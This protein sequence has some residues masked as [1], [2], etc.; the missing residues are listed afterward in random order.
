MSLINSNASHPYS[1]STS[2]VNKKTPPPLP[3]RSLKPILKDRTVTEG[4]V[5]TSRAFTEPVQQQR[6]AKLAGDTVIKYQSAPA[7][8]SNHHA[9]PAS[10]K[11]PSEPDV[12]FSLNPKKMIDNME[13]MVKDLERAVPSPSSESKKLWDKVTDKKIVRT[14][15]SKFPTK[16]SAER[17][18][19]IQQFK[20]IGDLLMTVSNPEEQKQLI[21]QYSQQLTRLQ[22]TTWGQDVQKTTPKLFDKLTHT[23][24]AL[25]TH[26]DQQ[27][28]KG[29]EVR[30]AKAIEFSEPSKVKEKPNLLKT[31]GGYI[32]QTDNLLAS[33]R[34]QNIKKNN[35][36]LF[37]HLLKQQKELKTHQ[38]NLRLTVLEDK[39]SKATNLTEMRQLMQTIEM[40]ELKDGQNLLQLDPTLTD[41]LTNIKNELKGK[42]YENM[43]PNLT[44][45]DMRSCI[46]DQHPLG[47]TISLNIGDTIP[48]SL[49]NEAYGDVSQKMRGD[50]L[51]HALAFSVDV[52]KSLNTDMKALQ[53]DLRESEAKLKESV[54]KFITPTQGEIDQSP[55]KE[56]YER[57]D[58]QEL[59]NEML[60]LQS[61]IAEAEKNLP[62]LVA[63]S[64]PASPFPSREALA[65]HLGK[66]EQLKNIQDQLVKKLEDYLTEQKTQTKEKVTEKIDQYIQMLSQD[67][68]YKTL[69]DEATILKNEAN[70]LKEAADKLESEIKMAKT[71][72][73]AKAKTDQTL[74]AKNKFAKKNNEYISKERERDEVGKTLTE[75]NSDLQRLKGVRDTV[76]NRLMQLNGAYN[77]IEEG[78]RRS[79]KQIK[80]IDEKLNVLKEIKGKLEKLTGL[81]LDVMYQQPEL[82]KSTEQLHLALSG[83][84]PAIRYQT[85]NPSNPKI[86][87]SH[88]DAELD[89]I[90]KNETSV[91]H[92]SR[93]AQS[94]AHDL[95]TINAELLS[96][97][98]H[99]ELKY[100]D[101]KSD[102]KG[103]NLKN[104]TK[105]YNAVTNNVT[106]N[107][108]KPASHITS[109]SKTMDKKEA[110]KQCTRMLEFYLDV[111]AECH[112]MQD[113]NSLFAIASSFSNSALIPII[114]NLSPQDQKRVEKYQTLARQG[115]GEWKAKNKYRPSIPAPPFLF[116]GISL[117]SEFKST[118]IDSKALDTMS[119][120]KTVTTNVQK[121]LKKQDPKRGTSAPLKMYTDLHQKLEE[122]QKTKA[123]DYRELKDILFPAS[124]RRSA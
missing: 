45:S 2:E 105:T 86:G 91:E 113:Y 100:S 80:S 72:D 95:Y 21:A 89:K 56:V 106:A 82:Q 71:P 37:D 110:A 83:E 8:P 35:P 88:L 9:T 52:A 18:K 84:T 26:L 46:Y 67:L 99:S 29:V 90:T 120:L 33:E 14:F 111:A 115:M 68:E 61:E 28:V 55:L 76:N 109:N 58:Y 64:N 32:S 15:L 123:P 70:S 93:I 34:A 10:S 85:L 69:H 31:L 13:T 39:S 42:F 44:A 74:E 101:T 53:F 23:K 118:D 17:Q 122:Q 24:E 117:K 94:I 3:D 47:S 124:Q 7:T 112:D 20:E 104:L 50:Q 4:A 92:R 75:K 116:T 77:N 41:R 36:A 103:E 1:P 73:E 43:G 54:T 96:R 121:Q 102:D 30:T 98:H 25:T 5:R 11:A 114:A 19:T 22:T 97:M 57:S 87:F 81:G 66:I 48:W 40:F 27:W 60:K 79:E 62:Q 63:V 119:N 12:T 49:V 6:I 38:A 108:F 65:E 59:K 16:L 107:I 51:S 78:I